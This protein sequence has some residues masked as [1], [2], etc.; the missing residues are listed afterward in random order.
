MKVK[1]YA[2]V[3]TEVSEQLN[4]TVYDLGEI[5]G[6]EISIMIVANI[7]MM[8][9]LARGYGQDITLATVDSRTGKNQLASVISGKDIVSVILPEGGSHY[10]ADLPLCGYEN[11]SEDIRN[12]L[13]LI[14][15]CI[16]QIYSRL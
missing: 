9:D 16:E 6:R 12:I 8:N 10:R 13:I 5:W 11:L 1:D 7:Y 4:D 15:A 14:Q 2:A 3:C